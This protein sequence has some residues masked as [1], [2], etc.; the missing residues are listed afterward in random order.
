MLRKF[1]ALGLVAAG[2]AIVPAAT[3]HAAGE[4]VNIWLTTTSDS[5]GRTV[6]RG[7]QPQAAIAFAPASASANQTITV[8]E[9]TTYQPFEGAGASFTDTAAYL[10]RGSGALSASTRDATMQKLFDPVNGI[11]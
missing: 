4:P 6:T 3:A 7:L 9:N 10:L 1:L 2:L 8:N 11:G 5:G